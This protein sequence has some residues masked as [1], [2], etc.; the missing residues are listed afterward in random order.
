[1]MMK[2]YY[3]YHNG[4]FSESNDILNPGYSDTAL[5]E[6]RQEGKKVQKEGSG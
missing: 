2:A 4:T 5:A 3:Y 6:Y 1:M